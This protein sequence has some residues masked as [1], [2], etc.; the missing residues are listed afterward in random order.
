MHIFGMGLNCKK[1]H[2]TKMID[3]EKVRDIYAA[4]EVNGD[5]TKTWADA[6]LT[7]FKKVFRYCTCS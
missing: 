4:L 7:V 6:K 5:M 2:S 1:M 3:S